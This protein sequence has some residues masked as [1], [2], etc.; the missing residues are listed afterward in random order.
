MVILTIIIYNVLNQYLKNKKTK[1]II[2][3]IEDN[4]NSC[5]V[6]NNI[7]QFLSRYLYKIKSLLY[8]L[9][10]P[11]KLNLKRYLIIK[12]FFSVSC[13][14]ISIINKNNMF[15]SILILILVFYI[16]NLSIKIFKNNEKILIIKELRNITNAIIISLSSSLSLEEAIKN[17][18]KIITN[19]RL[20]KEYELFISNYK[21]YS[22]N[23]KKAIN[24]LKQKF[25]YYEMELFASA[26]IN[27]ER[28]GNV[29]QSLEKYNMVLD[30][31][32]SKYLAKENAKRLMYLTLGT[33]VSLI[34]IVIIVMYPIF[35]EVSSNLQMIFR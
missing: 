5:R 31:S 10:Y 26:L 25:E 11:Y 19:K 3:D 34:N 13:F 8:N 28:E 23:M 6:I 22:Y 2:A 35:I 16:P 24:L 15:V 14:I 27:S 17:S 1:K 30:I 18:S 20:H 4:I 21:V 33:V 32:Y 29:I 12:Y 7:P 9:D